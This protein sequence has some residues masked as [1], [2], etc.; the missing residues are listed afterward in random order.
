MT[1]V[2]EIASAIR[3]TLE[4][5]PTR[6]VPGSVLRQ[7]ITAHFPGFAPSDYGSVKFSDFLRAHISTVRPVGRAGLDNVYG[8]VTDI[9]VPQTSIDSSLSDD[10]VIWKTF[11]SPSSAY[12]L[13]GNPES[14]ELIVLKPGV[15]KPQS[16][17]L[18]IPLSTPAQHL[19][20]AKTFISTRAPEHSDTLT[21]ILS[22]SQWWI[23][24]YENIKNLALAAKWTTFRRDHLLQ[25][26]Q[27]SLKDHNIS[28]RA[29]NFSWQN[30]HKS[31]R[32]SDLKVT[33]TSQPV[34]GHSTDRLR[35]IAL[36]LV[37]RMSSS[38]IR[39]LQ[40]RLGDVLDALD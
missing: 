33:A 4:M 1:S 37:G 11:T 10:M 31:V 35:R 15:E 7:V 30:T 13:F 28:A 20:I 24:F 25:L 21:P 18:Q 19:E 32:P 22:R 5:A 9:A 16:P 29:I 3:E 39:N 17:W 27:H 36:K 40:V 34:S 12:Q 6:T 23:E 38:E 14:G 8:I 26:F 2:E